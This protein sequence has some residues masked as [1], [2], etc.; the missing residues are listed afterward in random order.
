MSFDIV[1]HLGFDGRCEEAFTFY[2]NVLRGEIVAMMR[3]GDGPAD[4][5]AHLPEGAKSRIMH[6]RIIVAGRMLMGADA[7]PGMASSVQ[8]FCVGLQVDSNAEAERIFAALSEGGSVQMP[9][10]ETFWA[11]RFGMM[12]DRFGTPWLVNHEK[13]MA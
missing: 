4:M 12:T 1:P 9:I 7:P 11:H 5:C 2:A 13:P 3:Y 10:G 6:A 8:G